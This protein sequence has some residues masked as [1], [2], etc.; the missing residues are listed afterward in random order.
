VIGDQVRADGACGIDLWSA[1]T[2][3]SWH[4]P[5]GETVTY[6]FR[7]AGDIV[8]WIRE[9]EPAEVWYCSGSPGVVET[10]IADAMFD[11]GWTYSIR[12]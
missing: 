12:L 3:I 5:D 8:A 1:L 11:Q 4:S 10:W 2:N 7:Q 6:S 9:D